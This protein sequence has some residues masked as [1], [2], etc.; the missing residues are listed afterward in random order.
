[1][2]AEGLKFLII[3]VIAVGFAFEKF[4]SWLNVRR[5]VKGVPPPPEPTKTAGV[6]ILSEGQL[7]VWPGNRNIFIYSDPCF[8][9]VWPFWGN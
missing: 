3:G 9:L 7:P 8:Y 5:E 1:M 6:K 4:L 2:D